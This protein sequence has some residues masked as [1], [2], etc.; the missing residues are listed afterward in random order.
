MAAAAT[1][2]RTQGIGEPVL[3]AAEFTLINGFIDYKA[4]DATC[5]RVTSPPL[6]LRPRLVPLA[7]LH[8]EISRRYKFDQPTAWLYI[9]MFN[10]VFH[11]FAQL[12]GY[13]KNLG[14][15]SPQTSITPLGLAHGYDNKL[16]YEIIVANKT[17]HKGFNEARR[18]LGVMYSVRGAYDFGW[19]KLLHHLAPPSWTLVE[20]TDF[21][22]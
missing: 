5:T 18:E 12:P 16:A 22:E 6:T 2:A 9:H 15:D 14:L 1:D 8:T 21:T 20:I 13:F 3:S 19:T 4:W 7:A 10:N 11:S 17:A